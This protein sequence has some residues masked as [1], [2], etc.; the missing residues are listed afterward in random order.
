MTSHSTKA[1][2]KPF[3]PTD[4]HPLRLVMPPARRQA[5]QERL[6]AI[7]RYAGANPYTT[8]AL[9]TIIEEQ[10]SAGNLPACVL[11]SD[12]MVFGAVAYRAVL[13]DEEEQ[14]RRAMRAA[15]AQS[16]AIA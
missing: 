15:R 7:P 5:L 10:V 8:H 11:E 13:R 6:R 1:K 2:R 16:E 9:I 4:E 14:E 12:D 3:V